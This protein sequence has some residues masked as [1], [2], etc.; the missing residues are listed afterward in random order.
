LEITTRRK[1]EIFSKLR[2]FSFASL[3]FLAAQ[4]EKRKTA[5][6]FACIKEKEN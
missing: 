1:Q 3:F 2:A 4:K 6:L 5:V